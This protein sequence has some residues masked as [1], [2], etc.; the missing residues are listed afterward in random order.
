MNWKRLIT[1]AVAV[2]ALAAVGLFVSRSIADNDESD[3]R[4]LRRELEQLRQVNG[5]LEARNKADSTQLTGL[6][7]N[8]A[9]LEQVAREDLGFIREGE[10]VVILPK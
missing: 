8:Q 9:L 5:A 4:I 6:T 1:V 10:V 7:Q 2:L 3:A